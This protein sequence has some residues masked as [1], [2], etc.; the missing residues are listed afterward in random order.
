MSKP[1]ALSTSANEFLKQRA[2]STILDITSQKPMKVGT[3]DKSLSCNSGNA[4]LIGAPELYI[5]LRA[6]A[7]CSRK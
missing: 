4:P 2:R 6:A 7:T 5:A 3:S 1:K